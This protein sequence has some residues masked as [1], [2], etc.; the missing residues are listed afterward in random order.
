MVSFCIFSECFHK[1]KILL[2]D[3]L[4]SVG[5]TKKIVI[6]NIFGWLLILDIVTTY[7]RTGAVARCGVAR[8]FLHHPTILLHKYL[9][10]QSAL[11]SRIALFTSIQDS[12]E[13]YIIC[14][15]ALPEV[16]EVDDTLAIWISCM[17]RPNVTGRCYVCFVGGY[18]V[19]GKYPSPYICNNT[20]HSIYI[21]SMNITHG[22]TC[23]CW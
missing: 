11:T 3:W 17:F 8:K 7:C 14:T 12:N 20:I 23:D 18:A 1:A 4:L 9:C 13:M 16:A 10:W 6:I 5:P 19:F 22:Y 2:K 15:T 21:K